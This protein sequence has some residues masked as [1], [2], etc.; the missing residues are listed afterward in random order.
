MPVE[1]VDLSIFD[2][3]SDGD[4]LFIDSSH[5]TLQNSDVTVLF[6]EVIPRLK[7]GVVVQIHD[8]CLPYDYPPEVVERFYSEQ[9][10][11]A[12]YLLAEGS[13]IRVRLPNLFISYDN[14]LRSALDPLWELSELRT[15]DRRGGSFWFQMA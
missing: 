14:E 6:L 3:L 4:I 8:I 13:R 10:L 1:A 5:R 15:V 12:A 9:Y 2:D 7:P 11:L